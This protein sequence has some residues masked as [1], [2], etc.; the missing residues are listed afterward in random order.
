M[1]MALHPEHT[2]DSVN[3]LC[4][5]ELHASTRDRI[6]RE[7]MQ[8]VKED[9]KQPG[10]QE[11][12]QHTTTRPQLQTPAAAQQ[13]TQ[14]SQSRWHKLYQQAPRQQSQS[15][16]TIR[17]RLARDLDAWT[18]REPVC[19]KNLFNLPNF[20]SHIHLFET[21][22]IQVGAHCTLHNSFHLKYL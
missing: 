7:L 1:A 13:Q 2:L 6:I 19:S 8:F 5:E 18:R 12:A 10:L 11:E 20:L 14:T 9:G 16:L 15:N 3:V 17:A 4:S 21:I 22:Y